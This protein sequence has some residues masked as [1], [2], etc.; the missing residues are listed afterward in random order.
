MTTTNRVVFENFKA[1]NTRASKV[2]VL[3]ITEELQYNCGCGHKTKL[4]AEA[5]AHCLQ[6]GHTLSVL[7]RVEKVVQR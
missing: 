2:K 4:R 3:P 1:L 6:T 7:G 5:L